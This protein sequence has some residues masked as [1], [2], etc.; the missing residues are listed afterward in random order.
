[1]L[2]IGLGAA[3]F[4]QTPIAQT[5]VAQ[6]LVAQTPVA[7]T[8]QAT[9][10]QQEF[11]AASAAAERNDWP[12]A[13]A[14][15]DA[16][17]TKLASSGKSPRSLALV[18]VRRGEALLKVGR[19]REAE[20]SVRAG[21]A[22]LPAT[23]ASLREDRVFARL[24]LGGIAED[25]YDYP[26]AYQAYADALSEGAGTTL[27]GSARLGVVRA[28]TFVDPRKAAATAD[29]ALQAVVGTDKPAREKRAQWR[30]AKGRAL[31]N[32]GD[33]AGASA[34]LESATKELGGLTMTVSLSD[35][36]ARSDMAIA[37][38]LAGKPD[39]A[40]EYLAYTGAGRFE[41][42]YLP[43]PT[44]HPLPRCGGGTGLRA[45]DVAVVGLALRD[46]GRVAAATPIYGSRTGIAAIFARSAKAWTWPA[47]AVAKLP[48]LVR[49][50]TRLEV[51]CQQVPQRMS[52]DDYL[53]REHDAW[54]SASSSSADAGTLRD[55]PLA[56]LRARLFG[57]GAKDAGDVRA[58]LAAARAIEDHARADFATIRAAAEQAVVL[59]AGAGVPPLVHAYW[60]LTAAA[61]N[62]SDPAMSDKER[63]RGYE[64]A[65]A[66]A[67]DLP[68]IRADPRA[69][70]ATTLVRAQVL[71]DGTRKTRDQ[72]EA[73]LQSVAEGSALAA[74]DDL[75]IGAKLRL[76]SLLAADNRLGDARSL[77]ASAGLPVAACPVLDIE[78]TR[79]RTGGDSGDF[80][81][82]AMR[83]GFEGWATTESTIGVDRASA[84]RTLI[85][86]PPFVFGSSAE[87][88]ARSSRYA[89][90]FR[91][92]SEARCGGQTAAV[93]F[94]I[95]DDGR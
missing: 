94:V 62:M 71:N 74:D 88:V 47:E 83:W 15:F 86:Y 35:L 25:A 26:G 72:V 19:I 36:I 64:R 7:Q 41:G 58:R 27:E 68:A 29:G 81:D 2:A 1:M 45:D 51:R 60:L 53:K 89:P 16:L 48:A 43:T 79:S 90:S 31:L 5:L 21:L 34:E 4:A 10:R 93:R 63:L 40:R 18:R 76:A 84:V 78:R 8:P 14:R 12:D 61:S 75:R 39:K 28:G 44:D 46:N 73:L 77:Y 85:G 30:T 87:G 70:A 66:A 13:L 57:T 32:A 67:A 22:A 42:A 91:P 11:E 20:T 33:F 92:D 95:P 82:A 59:A 38:L 49:Q 17:E 50:V 56:T 23:D 52:T 3:L 65:I 24:M 55:L 54:A 69:H 6:T 80:P 9:G 37:A